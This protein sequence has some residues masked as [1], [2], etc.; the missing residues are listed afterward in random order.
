MA[1]IYCDGYTILSNPSDHGGGWVVVRGKKEYRYSVTTPGFTNNEAELRGILQAVTLANPKEKIY[2]DSKIAINWVN[3]R[4]AGSRHDLDSLASKARQLMLEKCL[5]LEFVPR[6]KNKAGILIEQ[7]HLEGTTFK[8]QELKKPPISDNL[9]EGDACPTCL[10][11]GR[12]GFMI[13]RKGKYGQF[14]GCSEYPHCFQSGKI[15]E[16]GYN[17]DLIRQ[18]DE[19]LKGDHVFIG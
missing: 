1:K 17:W 3:K 6:E 9:K 10:E 19:L 2:S 7:S 16:D 14:L 12:K 4:K 5:L 15:K 8:K 11:K 13:K 18:A